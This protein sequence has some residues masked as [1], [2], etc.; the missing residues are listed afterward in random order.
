MTTVGGKREA[1]ENEVACDTAPEQKKKTT[2]TGTRVKPDEKRVDRFFSDVKKSRWCRRHPEHMRRRWSAE[3]ICE[4]LCD[5]GVIS[6]P[7]NRAYEV[8]EHRG[9]H[10]FARVRSDEE[11][12]KIVRAAGSTE[13]ERLK[14]M[15]S[16]GYDRHWDYMG[17]LS[18]FIQPRD[19]PENYVGVFFTGV[20]PYG[21]T[22]VTVLQCER[23]LSRA[24]FELLLKCYDDLGPPIMIYSKRQLR[25]QQEEE[26]EEDNE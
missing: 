24:Q 7:D 21:D 2:P 18:E 23:C 12:E 22:K 13:E 20:H 5:Y 17:V 11:L 16:Q 1:P 3:L 14:A 19:D 4:K 15:H 6:W 26:E 25:E 9:I 8:L 10:L